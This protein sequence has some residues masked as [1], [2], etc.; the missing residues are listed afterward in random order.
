VKADSNAV[1]T[2]I[3]FRVFERSGQRAVP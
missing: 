2:R 1:I 3:R